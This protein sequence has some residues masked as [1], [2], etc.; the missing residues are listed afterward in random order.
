MLEII[1]KLYCCYFESLSNHLKSLEEG[2]VNT[3]Y[4]DKSTQLFNLI[5]IADSI[6]ISDKKEL[7]LF[8]NKVNSLCGCNITIDSLLVIENDSPFVNYQTEW[9]PQCPV[10]EKLTDVEWIPTNPFCVKEEDD[11]NCYCENDDDEHVTSPD[12][13]WLP[14]MPYCSSMYNSCKN[15]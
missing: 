13:I 3:L 2:V 9:I 14:V 15:Y 6:N 11:D 12:T 5:I 7:Q 10:C 8:I 1:G 4:K